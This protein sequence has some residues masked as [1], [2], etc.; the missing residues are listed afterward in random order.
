M[1]P[2]MNECF[3]LPAKRNRFKSKFG[4]LSVLAAISFVCRLV[5]VFDLF[6]IRN[7]NLENT[8]IDLYLGQILTVIIFPL[9]LSVIPEFL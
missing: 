5:S 8:Y 6:R 7:I 1:V 9:L 3:L 4:V 2:L